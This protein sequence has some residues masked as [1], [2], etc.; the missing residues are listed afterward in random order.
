LQPEQ[1]LDMRYVETAAQRLGPY[2]RP[3]TAEDGCR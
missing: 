3:Q 2:Q 1:I